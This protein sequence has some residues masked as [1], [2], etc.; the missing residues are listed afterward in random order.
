V[1]IPVLS[2]AKEEAKNYSSR[3]MRKMATAA[4]RK[5][6]SNQLEIINA[7]PTASQLAFRFEEFLT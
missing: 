2:S 7:D 4:N 1:D 5:S 3:L 6:R